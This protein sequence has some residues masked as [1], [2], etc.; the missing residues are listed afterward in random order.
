MVTCT[1]ELTKYEINYFD[2]F[3]RTITFTK[4]PLIMGR[5]RPK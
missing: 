5:V 3:C 4:L 2:A 1:R